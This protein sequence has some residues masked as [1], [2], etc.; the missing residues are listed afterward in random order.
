[1]HYHFH[2]S[3]PSI[4]IP[5]QMNPVFT[6]QPYLPKIHLNTIS[7]LHLV[8]RIV[9]SCRTFKP[10][11]CTHFSSSYDPYISSYWFD[12]PYNIW[13]T[14]Q[15]MGPLIMQFNPVFCHIIPLTSEQFYFSISLSW[16][17]KLIV[18]HLFMQ[19]MIVDKLGPNILLTF[20]FLNTLNLCSSLKV[21]HGV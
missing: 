6:L 14:V 18:R 5:S 1:V 19:L 17:H 20:M 11:F 7:H 13:W 8:L 12:N 16:F 2:K 3:S 9:S 15:N 21:R 10:T 4:P